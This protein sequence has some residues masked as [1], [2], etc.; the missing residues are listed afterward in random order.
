MVSSRDPGT[1][2]FVVLLSC[3][4]FPFPRGLRQQEKVEGKKLPVNVGVRFFL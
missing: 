1:F 4:M 3:R 2:F